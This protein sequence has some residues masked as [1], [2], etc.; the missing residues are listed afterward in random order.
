LRIYIYI[1]FSHYK[2]I[3]FF[4][5]L[6]F[7]SFSK[8]SCNLYFHYW[9]LELF[10]F[11]LI[12]PF[13]VLFSFCNAKTNITSLCGFFITLTWT[14]VAFILCFHLLSFFCKLCYIVGFFRLFFR[15]LF[16]YLLV[17]LHHVGIQVFELM[18]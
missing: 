2:Y 7:F 12:P 14:Y 15:A 16:I 13:F 4:C 3:N 18:L 5:P 6:C 11:V 1:W 8:F 17:L 9:S 10:T